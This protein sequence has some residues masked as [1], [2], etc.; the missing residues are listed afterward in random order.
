M[1][2]AA[3]WKRPVRPT[4]PWRLIGMGGET[5]RM[6]EELSGCAGEGA[7]AAAENTDNGLKVMMRVSSIDGMPVVKSAFVPG[8]KPFVPS[9]ALRAVPFEALARVWWANHTDDAGRRGAILRAAGAKDGDPIPADHHMTD[10]FLARVADRWLRTP[11]PHPDRT[12]AREAGVTPTTVR[13]WLTAARAR[14]L[15]PMK[16]RGRR[17]GGAR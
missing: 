17:A 10:E 16:P 9:T 1:M 11:G 13:R 7:W 4:K 14:A 6:L 12:I 2:P 8:L 5:A 3:P 15:L